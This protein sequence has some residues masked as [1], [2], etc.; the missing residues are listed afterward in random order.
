M[1]IARVVFGILVV[2]VLA[3]GAFFLWSRRPEIAAIDPS[4]RPAFDRALVAK[5]AQLAAIGDCDVCHTVP[6]G[7]AYAGSRPIPTPFGTIYSTNLTP[8]PETGIGS[9]PE[10]AFRRAMREGVARDGTYLY[11][12]FPY[13][14]YAK[15]GDDDLHALYGF[16]MTRTPVRSQAPSNALPFPLNIRRIVAVWDALYLDPTP[17]RPEPNQSGEWNR[18]AYLVAGLGHCGGCH[19][20]RNL[21][22]AEEKDKGLAGGE[23]EGWYAPALNAAS[24]APVPWDAQHLAAYLHQGWDTVHGAAAGPMAP[25]A[26]DTSQADEQDVR[27]MSVYVASLQGEIPPER[28]K[29]ADE[30]LAKVSQPEVPPVDV[31]ADDVGAIIF[32]GGCASCHVGGPSLVPPRG[33]DLA[34]STAISAPDPSNAIFILLDGIQPPAEQRGPWMP[35]FDGA[36]TDAQMAA[37]LGYVRAHY[38]DRPAWNDLERRIRSIRQ[39]KERS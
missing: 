5:G 6:G 22:G 26:S 34:L 20:P 17:F 27:A 28:R 18:G 30:L 32:A 38:S 7:P 4:R 15:V 1:W 23:A 14:H 36:F 25:V 29:R 10:E 35:R 19:A 8:D 2:L 21:L 3:A 11:P 12:A 16:I 9:W 31:R 39:G 33:I 37:L 24:P 13:D